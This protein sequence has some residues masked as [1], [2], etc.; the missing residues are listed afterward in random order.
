MANLLS[1]TLHN[2]LSTQLL[3]QRGAQRK[4]VV[5]SGKMINT[6]SG[7]TGVESFPGPSSVLYS[8]GS[9]ISAQ[10]NPE[11]FYIIRAHFEKHGSSKSVA[12][13]M[14]LVVLDTAKILAVSPQSILVQSESGKLSVSLAA[15][16]TINKLRVPSDQQGSVQTAI[17]A[18]TLKGRAIRA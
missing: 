11:Q 10:A 13:T 6:Y 14:A 7:G 12:E 16:S 3:Q 4:V 8:K 9:A 5:D 1:E 17:H 18:K 2:R 15:Y